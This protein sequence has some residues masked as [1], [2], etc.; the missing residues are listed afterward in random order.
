[1]EKS[2]TRRFFEVVGDVVSGIGEGLAETARQAEIERRNAVMRHLKAQELRDEADR[3][4]GRPAGRFD[5]RWEIAESLKT[6]IQM[7]AHEY[8]R[9]NPDPRFD[10]E[11]AIDKFIASYGLGFEMPVSI[12]GR[13]RTCYISRSG[14]RVIARISIF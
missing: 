11:Y 3:L 6:A 4:E 9:F 2:N 5:S 10:M 8:N 14:N 7:A 1:M 13:T 12:N